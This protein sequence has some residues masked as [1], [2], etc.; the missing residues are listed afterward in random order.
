MLFGWRKS[1]VGWVVSVH[2]RPNTFLNAFWLPQHRM[3]LGVHDNGGRQV[4]E[5]W[6]A[7]LVL[8]YLHLNICIFNMGKNLSSILRLL[9]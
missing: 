3:K 8:G 6:D 9:K 7:T 4:G 2:L 5:C 1:S